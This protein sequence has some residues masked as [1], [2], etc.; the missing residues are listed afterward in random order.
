MFHQPPP[1]NQAEATLFKKQTNK[2]QDAEAS[3][4]NWFGNNL[5]VLNEETR[6]DA[7]G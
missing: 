1:E 2:S 6:S 3:W 5:Q 4:T 7:R